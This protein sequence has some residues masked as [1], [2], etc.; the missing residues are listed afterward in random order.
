MGHYRKVDGEVSK[1][2]YGNA[3]A[4]LE[5]SKKAYRNMDY[6]LYCLD[7]GMLAHY[8]GQYEDSSRLLEDGE[9]A[10]E[11]AYAKSITQTVGTLLVN[12][13]TREY[14]G[15]DYED[16]YLNVFNAL[17]YYQRGFPEDAL[18]EIRRI[19]NKLQYLQVKYGTMITNLQQEALKNSSGIPFDPENVTV[20]FSNSA[21]ARY[22]SMLFYRGTGRWDDARIDRDQVRLAFANQ[23]DLYQFPLPGSL[24]EELD[25]PRDMARFNLVAFTGLS[26]VKAAEDMRIPLN[27]SNWVK[28]SLPVMSARPSLVGSVEAVFDTGQ[29]F[30]LEVIEDISAV[31]GETFKQKAGVIYLRSCIRAITKAATAAAL[32]D[33]K[34]DA[35]AILG[36]F[37]Q[38]YAEVSEQADL[39]V[40]RYFPGRA[41]AGGIT[42]EPGIYSYTVNFYDYSGSVIQSERFED[43]EIKNQ[44]LNLTE[45]LCLK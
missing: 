28:I 45:V 38:I 42:L 36:L 21:L 37:T 41:L 10:I 18:V 23:P 17:N 8:A 40:S 5:S 15:E 22:L 12:D 2:R 35:A 20:H 6:V 31:A 3:Y 34:S 19:T 16:I 39:R 29:R 14:S 9:R 33:R 27:R 24:D 30:T 32:S 43:V 44:G 1:G 26:P 13:M 11:A 4:S 7:S 25:F